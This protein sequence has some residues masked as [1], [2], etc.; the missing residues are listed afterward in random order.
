MCWSPAAI[1]IN[2][3]LHC[4]KMWAGCVF[5]FFE[6]E[7]Y[8]GVLQQ[9]LAMQDCTALRCRLTVYL[10]LLRKSYMSEFATNAKIALQ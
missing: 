4:I 9:L 1:A 5:G 7:L 6:E 8:V 10:A 3:R 2:E